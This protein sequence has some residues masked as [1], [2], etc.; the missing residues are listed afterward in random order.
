MLEILQTSVFEVAVR[1]DGVP[2]A[3]RP[4]QIEKAPSR[5]LLRVVRIDPLSV[6]RDFHRK[7]LA[8]SPQNPPAL[9]RNKVRNTSTRL[10][11]WSYF[12]RSIQAAE[13]PIRR[14]SRRS[15]RK[16]AAPGCKALS[17]S[18]GR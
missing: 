3:F 16:L 7:I 4:Y 13:Y 2:I 10:S 1:V 14:L 8:A 17:A 11:G 15:L 6:S 5:L 12:A 18:S 9:D